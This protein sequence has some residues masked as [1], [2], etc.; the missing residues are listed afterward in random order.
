MAAGTDNHPTTGST[1]RALAL[2]CHPLPTAGVTVLSAGLAGLAGVGFGRGLLFTVAVFA[3]Q[4]SIGWSNDWIDAGRDQQVGR[5]D[6][7]VARGAVA[8]GSVRRAALLAL[9]TTIV[10]SAGLGWRAGLAALTLVGAGWAYNLGLKS[11]PWSA[12]AYAVGF[13][14]LP[15][16]ATLARPGHP[17]PAWWAM[18]AGATLGLAAHAANVLPDLKSDRET[19]VRGFWHRLGPR[20][21]AT[22]GPALLV[23]ASALLL[24]GPSRTGWRPVAVALTVLMA[25]VA[26]GIGRRNPDS[27]IL[28]AATIALA[29]LDLLLFGLTGARLY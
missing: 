22:A 3:G 7:P 18:A 19:G 11:T 23:V 4:L 10:L 17:W 21:T 13:G 26:V 8:L 1:L 2:S 16:A 14:A 29:G 5:V 12:L 6:K 24:L 27:R 9:V 20:A 15:A 25:A 28:F